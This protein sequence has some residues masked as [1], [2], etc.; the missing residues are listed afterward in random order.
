MNRPPVENSRCHHECANGKMNMK[1]APV[2]R[3]KMN[4]L[5]I[6]NVK[7]DNAH[8]MNMISQGQFLRKYKL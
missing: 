7:H 5:T 2:G 3:T 8:G 1:K 6:V 4:F